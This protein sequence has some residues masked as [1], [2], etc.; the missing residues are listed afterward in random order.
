LEDNQ[1]R[2][3]L[4]LRKQL[5]DQI[6]ELQQGITNLESMLQKLDTVIGSG[7]FTTADRISGTSV[8]ATPSD[9]PTE[10]PPADGIKSIVIRSKD[11]DLDLA[12]IEVL[13]SDL[14]VIPEDHA[15]YD[16]KRGAFARFFVERI[17]GKFQQDD[18][19][20]VEN[21]SMSWEEA[22]D[23]EVHADESILEE[24]IIRNYGG[25]ERLSEIQR[26]LRW[27]LDKIYRAR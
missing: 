4:E 5:E 16:I 2:L 24:I 22:F 10:E 9:I 7:S 11:R 23:F 12:T 14:K 6:D 13:G 18:R 1:I 3:L 17:L 20:N 15:I 25:D 26:T 8:E 21:G 27:A 19:H